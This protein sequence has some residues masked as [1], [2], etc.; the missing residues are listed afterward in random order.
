M[1]GFIVMLRA[2]AERKA[3]VGGAAGRLC[4]LK[5][6]AIR[7]KPQGL[8]RPDRWTPTRTLAIMLVLWAS[9]V[10]TPF[11]PDSRRMATITDA[12]AGPAGSERQ[13][14]PRPGQRNAAIDVLRGVAV[15]GVANAHFQLGYLPLTT[16]EPN[17]IQVF[18]YYCGWVGVDLFF[19]LSGFLVA[20]LL[21]HE[22]RERGSVSPGRFLVRR[23][24]K[25]YP[26]FFFFLLCF[27]V[28]T[29]I[30]EPRSM[31]DLW[32][33]FLHE[34]LFVQNY[35]PAIIGHTWSLAVEEHFYI[36]LALVIY[37]FSRG[38]TLRR[39]RRFLGL[40]LAAILVVTCLRLING[41]AAPH[42]RIHGGSFPLG[43]QWCA[44]HL[45]LDGLLFGVVL[46]YFYH[47]EHAGTV[48]FCRRWSAVLIPA[49]LLTVLA[50]AP[51]LHIRRVSLYPSNEFWVGTVGFTLLY[52][53]W[54]AVLMGAIVL[55][56][57]RLRNP[58]ARV[59]AWIGLY[60][61]SMYLWHFT[62]VGLAL[63]GVKRFHLETH[64]LLS[65]ACY[66]VLAVV[67]GC[68]TAKAV[69][70]PMLALRDRLY[71]RKPT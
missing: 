13:S 32:P 45:R 55:P 40:A 23:G 6:R 48:Q 11:L 22:Y 24:F 19:V 28:K 51:W 41:I 14:Q 16:G 61:Y 47:F 31:R 3:C 30:A 18:L 29:I 10:R 62:A 52:L 50:V 70:M 4:R 46:A 71:P 21:F 35:L 42:E 68:L 7:Q 54:G 39:P 2:P 27:L 49:G 44:T 36:A 59:V 53:G 56:E 12:I 69:E 43:E 66:T 57:N 25:I 15:L 67:I 8:T 64:P 38:E 65:I 1:I 34:A 5:A 33:A 9:A 17:S 60:S 63:R 37:F 58:L 20:G 26:G